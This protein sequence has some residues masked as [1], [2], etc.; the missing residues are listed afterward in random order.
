MLARALLAALSL[1]AARPTKVAVSEVE[2]GLRT[3]PQLAK[4]ITDLVTSELRKRP[5]LQVAS[6][7]DIKA[8]LGFERQKELLGCTNT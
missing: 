1:L 8:L 6:Q 2:A 3:D 7:E 5:S 4:I